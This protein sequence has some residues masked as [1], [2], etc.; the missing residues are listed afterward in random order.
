M[1]F[2]LVGTVE[3]KQVRHEVAQGVLVVGRGAEAGLRLPVA[4]V[5]RRHAEIH[6]DGDRVMLEDLGSRN[7]TKVNGRPVSGTTALQA[8]DR[9]DFAGIVLQV[10]GAHP[11]D[12]TCYNESAT[13]VPEEEISWEEV[14]GERQQKR[15]R[16]SRLF[17]IL[18]D[19]GDLITI[20][21]APE[22]LYEPILDLVETALEPERSFILLLQ[23]GQTDPVIVAKRI[24]GARQEDSLALS[25]T[26][27]ARVLHHRTSFLTTD[28]VNDPDM[29]GA[30]SMVSQSIRTAVAAPLFDNEEVIGLLYADDTRSKRISRDELRAFTNLANAIAVALTH[31]RYH[32]MEEEKRRQDAQL[33][34]AGEILERILPSD[35]PAVPGWELSASLEPCYEVGGDLYDARLMPDG[36]L[37]FILGDVTGKG[38]GAA[39]LVSQVL[40]LARFMIG[41]GWAP[42]PLMTR[43]NREI[44]LTTDFVRFTTAFL[45]YLDPATGRVECVNAGHN[46][47]LLVR[48][49]GRV[50]TCATGSLPVGVLEDTEYS[51]SEVVMGPGDILA[52]FSDGIPE[53]VDAEDEEYGED[54]FGKVVAAR[55]LTA[56][57]DI[58]AAALTDLA[59]FRGDGEVGDDITLVMLRRDP[60]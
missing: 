37:A 24:K 20:P 47:P 15:D 44:F 32:Q 59:L 58:S 40:S 2:T 50:E 7:G 19:A 13:L 23:E 8:G 38:L 29:D 21:R 45:G 34:T 25:R 30:M 28:P 17:Q 11:V 46:P 36:R 3:G 10:E 41:E 35:L 33:A 14:R 16:Q 54:R 31:G 56:L 55:R 1:S 4:S 26:M 12:M 43:L 6:R 18:A 42:G 5:S 27:V 53:T 57:K 60:A 39:L 51:V 48:A 49:D 22:E 9:I 52:V